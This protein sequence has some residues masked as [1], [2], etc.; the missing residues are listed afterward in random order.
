MAVNTQPNVGLT[1]TLDTQSV[2]CQVID[3]NYK[4][5]G[6]GNSTIVETACP[7]GVV[8]EPGSITSGSLTGNAFLDSSDTGLWWLLAQAYE[9]NA[10]IAYVLTFYSELGP[11]HGF[12]YSGDARVNSIEAPFSKPGLGRHAIDLEIVSATL[13]R[14]TAAA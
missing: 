11:T 13:A 12:T 14:T 2:A 4:P 3:L 10:T 5:P 1:L 6:V 9:E 7:D 8:S